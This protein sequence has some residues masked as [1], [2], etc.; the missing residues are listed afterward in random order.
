MPIIVMIITLTGS[1]GYTGGGPVIQGFTSIKACE[2]AIPLVHGV[3]AERVDRIKC[4]AI[5]NAP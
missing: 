4:I 5:P 2:K 3:Y 1:Y